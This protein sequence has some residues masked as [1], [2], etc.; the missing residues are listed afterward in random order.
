MMEVARQAYPTRDTLMRSLAELVGDQLRGAHA[1][2][3]RATLAVPGEGAPVPFLDALAEADLAWEDVTVMATDER[4]GAAG[5]HANA[6]LIEARLGRGAAAR[7]GIL[8]LAGDPHRIARRLAAVLPLDVLVVASGPDMRCAALVS[9]AAG[10]AAALA[11]D[12]PPVVEIRPPGEAE[13]RVTLS[14]PVLRGASVIHVLITGGEKEA[15]L[16]AALQEGP[17]TEA[18]IR[19]VLA[20]P[21][22]VTVHYAD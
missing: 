17:E 14:A 22:P 18:P 11:P 21:C 2:K 20:A 13:A 1:S 16:R 10:L 3:H 4:R 8:S 5:G 12:A 7:A 6:R 9:G 15:T 19:V